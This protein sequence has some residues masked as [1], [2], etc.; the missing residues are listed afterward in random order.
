MKPSS[1]FDIQ[2]TLYEFPYHYLPRLDQRKIPRLHRQLPW[3]LDYLTYMS[4][5]VEQITQIAPQSLLDIGCGD[6]CLIHWVKSAVP[7]VSGVDLSE[8]A[9]AFARA[10][11][12]EVIFQCADIATITETYDCVTLIEVLEHI[13]D[14]QIRKFI[15]NVARLVKANG[16]LL[17][18][19][20][21]INVPLNKKHYR[22]YD[23]D[24][25]KTTLEPCFEIEQYW[26]MYRRGLLER[27]LRLMM[28]NRFYILNSSLLLALIWRIHTRK[29]YLADASTGAH[30]VCLA[31]P[32]G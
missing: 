4:F 15:G 32:T 19:V 17:V 13:P 8:Q 23:L 24:L 2:D 1:K 14:E 6:G 26:W 27:C 11:N 28:V 9:I 29:T 21:T 30:L 25:L 31:K 12:P 10:F 5:M 3:G 20:P 22:H 16:Y 18:S 7:Q